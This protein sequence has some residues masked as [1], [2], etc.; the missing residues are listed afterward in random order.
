MEFP[1]CIYLKVQDESVKENGSYVV[2]SVHSIDEELDAMMSG[3]WVKSLGEIVHTIDEVVKR[4]RKKKEVL[5]EQN[6]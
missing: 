4:T 1:K 2:K 3:E 5:D 6:N